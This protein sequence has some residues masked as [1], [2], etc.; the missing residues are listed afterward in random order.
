MPVYRLWCFF[1][2]NLNS[3]L[4]SLALWLLFVRLSGLNFTRLV[5]LTAT[6]YIHLYSVLIG[7]AVVDKLCARSS[8]G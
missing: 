1:L 4:H 3:G 8:V 6:D 5:V 7:L 2:K